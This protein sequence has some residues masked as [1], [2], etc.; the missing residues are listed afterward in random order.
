[1]VV[2]VFGNY[3]D[4]FYFASELLQVNSAMLQGQ[5]FFLQGFY[6]VKPSL[7]V[8]LCWTKYHYSCFR[9]K[10]RYLQGYFS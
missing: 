7:K 10:W 1:M 4:F 9:A 8:W 5:Q 6:I 2:S 3:G